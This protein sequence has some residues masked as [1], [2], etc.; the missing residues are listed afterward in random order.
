MNKYSQQLKNLLNNSYSPY[1]NFKVAAIV[2]TKNGKIYEGVNVENASY[3]GTICAERSAIV[4]AISNGVKPHEFKEIH[5]MGNC[6]KPISPCGLC[7]QVMV[8][9]FQ[10]DTNIVMMNINDDV[11]IMTIAELVPYSFTS[12]DL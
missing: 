8:E 2:V 9:L 7:R 3:G 4:S 11:K 6:E 12:K 10:Q 1:S 5:I